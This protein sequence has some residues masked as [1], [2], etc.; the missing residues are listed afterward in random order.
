LVVAVL[1]WAVKHVATSNVTTNMISYVDRWERNG[2]R[3]GKTRY[4][5]T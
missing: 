2:K 5:F 1:F 3:Q 4:E